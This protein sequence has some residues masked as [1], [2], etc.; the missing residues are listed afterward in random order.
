MGEVS[1]GVY[2]EGAA[3]EHQLVLSPYQIRVDDGDTLLPRPE[4][5][6]GL[7][8][9][10]LV[11]MVGRGV[12]VDQQLGAGGRGPACR[13]LLPDV[14]AHREGDAYPRNARMPLP[15]PG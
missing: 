5:D 10:G 15:L 12:D 4:L 8:L 11:E 13:A 1:R 14:L 3:I 9:R 2:H 6:Q 7:T